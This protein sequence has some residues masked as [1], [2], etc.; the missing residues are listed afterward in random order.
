MKRIILL[1][2]AT[3]T[4]ISALLLTGQAMKKEPVSVDVWTVQPVT[5]SDTLMCSGTVERAGEKKI[6]ASENGVVTQLLVKNGDH[7]EKGQTI[8]VL[9][10]LPQTSENSALQT[11]E[12]LWEEYQ[13]TGVIPTGVDLTAITDSTSKEETQESSQAGEEISINSTTEGTV[14]GLS[15]EEGET[16]TA[17]STLAVV[18]QDDS[19]RAVLYVNESLAS[20]VEVG[21]RAE[22]TGVGFPDITFE[23]EILSISDEAVQQASTTGKETVVEVVLQV[24]NPTDD[25][26]PGY[27]IKAAITTNEI[28]TLF[29]IQK[30]KDT[31]KRDTNIN[32][33]KDSRSYAIEELHKMYVTAEKGNDRT[34]LLLLL[35]IGTGARINELLNISVNKVYTANDTKKEYVVKNE[36][37]EAVISIPFE[38]YIVIHRQRS[39]VTGKETYAKTG[40]SNRPV[41][42]CQMIMDKLLDFISRHKLKD[43]D[44]IFFST[45]VKDKS[46]SISDFRA[47]ELL[48]ELEQKA[49]VEHIKGRINH[50]HRHDLIT[51][52]ENVFQINEATVRFFVGHSPKK[53][54]AHIRY[55]MVG[56]EDIKKLG[57]RRFKAAQTA[58]LITV[59]YNYDVDKSLQI[60]KEYN[61]KYE[62]EPYKKR[63]ND[64]T[65]SFT[66]QTDNIDWEKVYQM[67]QNG[68]NL[69]EIKAELAIEER[70][71]DI[72]D[73]EV[74][75]IDGFLRTYEY[76]KEW[77]E[78]LYNEYRNANR[79]VRKRFKTFDDYIEY[80]K[81]EFLADTGS[82]MDEEEI[83]YEMKVEEYMKKEEVLKEYYNL[84]ENSE[85]RKNN[86]FADFK[87]DVAEES[88]IKY[89][90]KRYCIHKIN[91][92]N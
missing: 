50:A 14:S 26:K 21:Q 48:R 23:G 72:F 36:D 71:E 17:G 70:N 78:C 9:K 12:Q 75:R 90:F 69:Q 5:A 22:I 2:L 13:Q 29:K 87:E 91:Y 55:N 7:V 47:G 8:A 53:N 15:A 89:D 51:Y 1:F 37:G 61:G 11:Y 66:I 44:K 65:V 28:N 39:R 33:L 42:L 59:M 73:E 60:F 43:N 40:V 88:V 58:F 46:H 41:V 85:Y 64:G 3:G 81:S 68:K 19:L 27:T 92:K 20:Q 4:I 56:A 6:Y 54:D 74:G 38:N 79:D 49:G 82:Y 67:E 80:H 32:L 31:A 52:F 84:S 62:T 83:N 18:A 45:T 77:R 16:V 34:F 57:A 86:T 76:Y 25:I 30:I 35:L 63:L 24:L 10:A